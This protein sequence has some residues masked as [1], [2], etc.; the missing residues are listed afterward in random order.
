VLTWQD[1]RAGKEADAIR[2]RLGDE[3]IL[4]I[5]GRRVDPELAA[6][7]LMWF[8]RHQP[9]ACDKA[10]LCLTLKDW[11]VLRLTGEAVTDPASAS[12]SLLFDVM[13]GDWSASILDALELSPSLLPNIRPGDSLAGTITPAASAET[14]LSIGTP[15]A[16]GGPDGTV[17]GIGG[18]LTRPGVAVDVM[19]TTDV[20]FACTDTVPRVSEGDLVI[21]AY[22]S[23]GLWSIGGPM[24]ATGGVLAWMARILG[25]GIA[26]LAH[27]AGQVAPG[28]LGLVFVPTLAG[29]RTPHW[30]LAERGRMS[31]LALDHSREHLFRA[32]MEGTAFEVAEV[33]RAF[34]ERNL[35]ISEL[36]A[37]GGGTENAVWLDIRAAILKRPLVIPEVTEAS[38]LGSAMMAAVGI[39]AFSNLEEAGQHMIRISRHIEPVPTLVRIYEDVLPLWRQE[40][41]GRS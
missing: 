36:R 15:V 25:A 14:G 6:A 27:E 23:G 4:R 26:T 16:V 2:T 13:S 8:A 30:N 11:L 40:R 24:G 18:G 37:V 12:Y 31:G 9:D 7:R 34:E 39:G 20:I 35:D 41:E 5:T 19:G 10:E 29:S 17:G 32:A 3:T 38:A 22:P 1:R 28:C 33:F 21:N